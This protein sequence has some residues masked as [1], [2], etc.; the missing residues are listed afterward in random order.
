[1]KTCVSSYSF[2]PLLNS[3]Q[4]TQLNLIELA[5][6]MGFEGI[7]FT[8]IKPP[9]GVSAEDYA[10]ALREESTK[11]RLPI[12]NYTVGA[13]FLNCK[14]SEKETERLIRQVEIAKLLG[15]KGMRHDATGG[16]KTQEKSYKGFA[17]ALPTLVHCCGAVSDYAAQYGISTMVE[18]HGYFCQESSRVE[19]LVNSVARPNFGALIDVGN[20]VCAD[21]NPASAVGRLAPYVKHVHVKDFYIRSGN[22]FHPG[23]GFFPSRGGQYLR[24]A[25][26]GQ[27]DVPVYQCLSVL[28]NSGYDG[29][30]SI[31]FEGMEES[32][33]AI[34]IA[35]T[36]LN[37][38][39]E[40]LDI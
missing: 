17:Q 1:M 29:Y 10:V 9:E 3:G 23:T 21:D 33:L 7:E 15:A 35:L 19:Q 28:K 16:Y 40:F 12:V 27:G 22:G 4:Y 31:E 5:A 13:D 8:D 30:V 32:L 14:D 39:I 34:G 25:I 26:I 24:G 2:Q 11:Q 36:N 20:F 18:N 6:D 37:R 38:M